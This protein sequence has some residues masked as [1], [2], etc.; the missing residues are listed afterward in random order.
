MAKLTEIEKLELVVEKLGV[1]IG[2]VTLGDKASTPEELAR[3]MR[4]AILAVRKGNSTPIDL[5][6]SSLSD[7][8]IN[9]DD[10]DP[11]EEPINFEEMR[12]K[13]L[14]SMGKFTWMFGWAFFIETPIGNFVWNSPSYGGDNTVRRFQGTYTEYSSGAIGR[15]KGYHDVERYCGPDILLSQDLAMRC[16]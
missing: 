3:E 4:K 7:A 14:S 16:C 6:E 1:Q 5:D 9:F 2:G 10:P 8:I 11:E 12:E 15:D 13:L